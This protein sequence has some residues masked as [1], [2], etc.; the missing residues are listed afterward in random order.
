VETNPYQSPTS[1][2]DHRLASGCASTLLKIVA[3]GCW[4]LSVFYAASGIAATYGPNAIRTYRMS[5]FL[6]WITL[7]LAVILPTCCL[8]LLGLASWRRSF[9]FAIYGFALLVPAICVFA[10]RH[11]VP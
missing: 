1:S 4:L 6:F 3:V 11:F 8:V 7:S 9:R 10:Y 2:S 5:P